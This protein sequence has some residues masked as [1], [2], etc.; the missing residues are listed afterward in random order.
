MLARH[1]ARDDIQRL[2]NDLTLGLRLVLFLAIPAAAGL[3]LLAQ[4]LARLLFERGAFT[5][6]D[7]ARTAR[8]IAWYGTGAWAYCALPV[9]V[10]GFYALGDQRT[11]VRV[12]AAIVAVNLSLNLLLIWPMAEAGLALATS[13]SAAVQVVL[14]AW[15]LGRRRH[16]LG[17]PDLG[18]TAIR[19]VV[20]ASAMWGAGFGLLRLLP[21]GETIGHQ[22]IRIAIPLAVCVAVYFTAYVALRGREPWMLLGRSSHT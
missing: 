1:A 21:D 6:E 17:W 2:G 10:R 4:P 19:S 3:T 12:G 20:A 5:A 18:R 16:R 11:P 22:A 15:I 13:A 7:T 9:L 8:M 14:L